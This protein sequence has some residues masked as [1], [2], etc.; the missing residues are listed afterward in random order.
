MPVGERRSVQT[1]ELGETAL[2]DEMW[3]DREK[4]I[5]RGVFEGALADELASTIADVKAR[6][7][8]VV[9]PEDMWALERH[10]RERRRD[11]D[12]KYDY[13]YSQLVRVFGQLLREGRIREEQLVGLS[14]GKLNDIRRCASL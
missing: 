4:R 9:A 2:H 12:R 14:E 10:L 8:A 1:S 11:I 5:A 13:R 7:A 3:T 6:A